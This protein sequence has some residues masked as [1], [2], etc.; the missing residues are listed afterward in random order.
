MIICARSRGSAGVIS[1]ARGTFAFFYMR[2]FAARWLP[3]AFICVVRCCM[4]LLGL[5]V[6]FV[7]PLHFSMCGASR[8]NGFL[9]RLRVLTLSRVFFA[10]AL[11]A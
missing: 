2:G 1:S 9:A 5:S 11:E 6:P 7:A 8:L 4:V 10:D 3:G